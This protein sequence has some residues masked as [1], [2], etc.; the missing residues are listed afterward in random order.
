MFGI[1]LIALGVLIY[2]LWVAHFYGSWVRA[3]HE[4]EREYPEV[5]EEDLS[6]LEANFWA[7]I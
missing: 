7:G 6:S 1:G 3:V 5:S 2:L 4:L